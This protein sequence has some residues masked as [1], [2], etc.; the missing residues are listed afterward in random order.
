[1]MFVFMATSEQY[2][3]R[4]TGGFSEQNPSTFRAMNL[5]RANG[6]QVGFQVLN[7]LKTCL[8]EP[9]NSVG[10]K[11]NLALTAHASKLR[12]RLNRPDF[13]I[14]CHDR[15]KDRISS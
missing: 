9:L 10:M 14:R 8:A 1:A 2:W 6:D 13:V 4:E 3:V 11:H 15:N 12:D 7:V 5:M